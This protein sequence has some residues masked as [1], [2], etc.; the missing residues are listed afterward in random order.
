MA[1]KLTPDARSKAL[2]ELSGWSETDGRD[3]ISKRFVFKDFNAAFGFMAR[4]ALVA[5]KLDHHPE[6]FNVYKT[7]DVTLSTH[8]A[9]GLT[10]LDVKLAQSHGPDRRLTARLAAWPC[11]R[12]DRDHLSD[13]TQRIR[14][15]RAAGAAA[16][17]MGFDRFWRRD[18]ADGDRTARDESTVRQNLWWKLRAGAVRLPFVEDL[19]TAYYCALDRS[20]P[21]RV[22]ATLFGALAYFILPADS[23]PDMLPLLGYTDDA[24]VLAAAI[25]MVSVHIR[26]EHRDAA[27]RALARLQRLTTP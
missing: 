7:V 1:E 2:A 18:G 20:T 8:D 17:R 15:M 4:A 12:L 6:W 14:T 23:L 13:R 5:E 25:R 21:M 9:G 24:A 22:R 10:E 3:A 16:G 27:R 19:V 11:A 26:T